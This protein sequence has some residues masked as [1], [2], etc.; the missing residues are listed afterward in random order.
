MHALRRALR[1]GVTDDLRL[2]RC[3]HALGKARSFAAAFTHDLGAQIEG[4]G[5][6]YWH[7]K[8]LEG[9]VVVT[10]KRLLSG[11]H[12]AAL[13]T[14]RIDGVSVFDIEGLVRL[15]S[16]LVCVLLDKENNLAVLAVCFNTTFAVI[17]AL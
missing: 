2:L 5:K 10:S 6:V 3:L 15:Q 14:C 17:G 13:L 8:L 12:A 1:H 11:T 9:G 4:V 7:N 16:L